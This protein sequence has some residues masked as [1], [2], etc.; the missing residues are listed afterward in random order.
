MQ[1][2]ELDSRFT[3]TS[4]YLLFGWPCL[5]SVDSFS[6]FHKDKILRMVLLYLV[7][8]DEL[9]VEDLGF[10][11]DTYIDNVYDDENSLTWMDF[12]SSLQGWLK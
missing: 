5:S 6:R 4:A 8:F 2:Q 9:P 1:L 11:L 12:M 10:E 7:D 3:E